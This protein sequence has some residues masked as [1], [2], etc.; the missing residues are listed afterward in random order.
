MKLIL[1]LIL[2]LTMSL[3]PSVLA[4]TAAAANPDLSRH[5]RYSRYDFGE[6]S[7]VINFGTQ[8]MAVPIGV[9]AE[10]MKRDRILRNELRRQGLE[11]RFHPFLKGDD[12]NFFL[13]QGKMDAAMVGDM[14]TIT[15][16]ATTDI[17]VVALAKQ[18]F[19][20]IVAKGRLTLAGLKGKRIGYPLVSNAHYALLAALAAVDLKESDVRLVPMEISEM[21]EA[22]ATGRIDAFAAWEPVPS[23]ARKKIDKATILFRHLN[24]SYLY[25]SKPLV[26]RHPEAA[27]LLLAAMI[28]ALRWMKENEENL[29]LASE[30]TL[31]AE[32]QLQGKPVGLTAADVADLTLRQIRSIT[33]YPTIPERDLTDKGSLRKMFDFLK[34]HGKLAGSTEW[35]RVAGSFDRGAIAA[36]LANQRRYRL[37][38][39]DYDMGKPANE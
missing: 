13:K 28:R 37:R 26:D 22:L 30:W 5:P 16:S 10:V 33:P 1:P 25:F 27:R 23:I 39:F 8:P 24:S 38:S 18:G 2:L 29:R 21:V 31:A 14:P 11:I 6:P 32:E 19:S 9:I 7:R 3:P 36:I 15:T 20:S 35:G 17:R 4:G 34:S 12:I